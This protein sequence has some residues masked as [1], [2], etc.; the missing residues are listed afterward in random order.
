[1][2]LRTFFHFFLFGN[3]Q[4][5]DYLKIG[6]PLQ[7]VLW[8][9]STWVLSVSSLWYVSW[10]ISII[11]LIVVALGRLGGVALLNRFSRG[12]VEQQN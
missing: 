6:A 9:V 5:I 7:I 3:Q 12:G 8:L 11:V 2:P 4:T 1:M 10:V